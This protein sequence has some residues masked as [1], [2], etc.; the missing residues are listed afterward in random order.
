MHPI[1]GVTKKEYLESRILH[2]NGVYF[3]SGIAYGID[4][5]EILKAESSVHM[6]WEN[7]YKLSEQYKGSVSGMIDDIKNYFFSSHAEFSNT[8]GKIYKSNSV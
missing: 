8:V 7:F 1:D 5:D 3:D 2:K 4:S 6:A